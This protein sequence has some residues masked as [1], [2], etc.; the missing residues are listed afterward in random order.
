M[1]CENVARTVF[2]PPGHGLGVEH[3]GAP[4][5]VVPPRRRRRA[6]VA[7]PGRVRERH[8]LG[9]APHGVGDDQV[10]GRVVRGE[11]EVVDR[12]RPDLQSSTLDVGRR[13]RGGLVGNEQPAA[14]ASTIAA[15]ALNAARNG[16]RVVMPAILR[17]PG[18]PRPK[19]VLTDARDKCQK[20]A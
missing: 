4:R 3:L 7:V 2:A 12:A 18:Q 19:L 13:R 1:D 10:A 9:V 5:A 14:R 16:G 6:R 8:R 20:G 11:R 15:M 17:S